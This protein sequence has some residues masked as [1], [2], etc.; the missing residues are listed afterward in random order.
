MA[1]TTK[2]RA[3]ELFK[4]HLPLIETIGQTEFRR[5]VMQQ[6]MAEFGIS[7]GS[8]S[9]LYNTAKKA[10]PVEGLGR[11]PAPAGVKKLSENKTK[12]PALVDDNDCFTVIEIEKDGLVGRC[13]SFLL[14]GDASEKFDEKVAAISD[15][16]WVL[17]RGLGPIHGESYSLDDGEV[18]IKRYSPVE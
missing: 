4:Q 9:T 3:L 16:T 5:T 15:C 2:E 17:I 6:L 11:E 7:Q 13:Q 12:G 1:I 14:Q 10:N 18:E 8:A